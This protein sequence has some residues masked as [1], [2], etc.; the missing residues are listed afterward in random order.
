MYGLLPGPAGRGPGRGPGLGRPEGLFTDGP[1][2]GEL[3]TGGVCAEPGATEPGA[4]GPAVAGV[5]A[6][7]VCEPPAGPDRGGGVGTPGRG[8]VCCVAG[9][10]SDP[11]AGVVSRAEAAAGAFD[12]GAPGVLGVL[13]RGVTTGPGCA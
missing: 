2:A 12:A 10:E 11:A 5:C 3:F 6:G 1:W 8:R 7:G 13:G 4:T 9:E